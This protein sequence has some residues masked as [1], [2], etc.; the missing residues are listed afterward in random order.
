MSESKVQIENAGNKIL[1]KITGSI[2]EDLKFPPPLE[3]G[4]KEAEVDFGSV[5]D[6]NSCGIREWIKWVSAMSDRVFYFVHCPKII[7]DQINMVEGF[8]PKNSRVNSFYVPIFNEVS[9]EEKD[10]LYHYGK[11]YND[12]EVNHP[13]MP[14]DA[15]GNDFEINVIES[16]YFKFIRG[17]KK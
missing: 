13:A 3:G 5:T 7:V 2:N 1:V 16:K 15:S 12:T 11:D 6:I 4:A 9:G 17:R 10:L 14:K 8:L